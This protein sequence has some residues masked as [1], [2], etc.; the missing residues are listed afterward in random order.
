MVLVDAHCHL[1]DI[2]RYD[3][4]K[5]IIPVVVG[6]SDSSNKKAFALAKT[7]NYPFVLGIAPQTAIKEGLDKLESW[8]SFIRESK[9]N[10]IGE[11]GL[12][13][14]W[15]RNKE[16]VEKE[17]A[18]FRKMIALA[19]EM[20]L[21][22]VIHSRDKPND[23][24]RKDDGVPIAAVDEC[25]KMMEGKRFVMHF[26]S[27]T[28][29]QAVRAIEL[30]GYISIIHMRSKERRK[31]INS[32]PMDKI[33]IESDAPFVGRTPESIREAVD[34]IAEVKDMEPEIVA[35]MSAD[36]AMRFFGFQGK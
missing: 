35:K 23:I 8:V 20:R 27:G 10:A 30:G 32:V 36:N 12:D 31:V 28:E 6:Y 1:F 17:R 4:P 24:I 33:L 13:Y 34:Y 18:L 14:K 21:P 25:I 16:D 9:P 2:K 15:A 7:K 11:I 3:I 29:E 19:D 26:F 5:D 22:M